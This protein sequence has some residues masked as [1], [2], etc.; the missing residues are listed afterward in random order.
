M[1][2]T[3]KNLVF[4]TPS[5]IT[6]CINEME[7]LEKSFVGNVAIGDIKRE[8]SGNILGNK[9]RTLEILAEKQYTPREFI[10]LQFENIIPNKLLT[11]GHHIYRGILSMYGKDLLCLFDYTV[12]ERYPEDEVKEAKA[13][14]REEIK[15][16]G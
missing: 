1:F 12:G 6:E 16:I 4:K 7:A 10:L 13:W 5:E 14:I 3:I 11:G 9:N 15:G 2:N 8:V